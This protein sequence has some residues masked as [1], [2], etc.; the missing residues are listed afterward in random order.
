MKHFLQRNFPF[1]LRTKIF[2]FHFQIKFQ[3]FPNHQ[4]N[5][6]NTFIYSPLYVKRATTVVKF[7]GD[8]LE[9]Q[10]IMTRKLFPLSRN[11]ITNCNYILKRNQFFSCGF[12]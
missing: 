4:P 6:L 11:L 3:K 9:I 8:Q 10:I 7:H 5:S 2:S 12:S 1:S